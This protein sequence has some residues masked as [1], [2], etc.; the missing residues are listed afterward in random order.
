[1]ARFNRGQIV[2]EF[3]VVRW[4]KLRLPG[5]EIAY[6]MHITIA[7]QKRELLQKI[8]KGDILIEN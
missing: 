5:G 3:L 8:E 6:P 7:A 4:A 2:K 1:M